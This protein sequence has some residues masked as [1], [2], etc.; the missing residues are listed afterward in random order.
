MLIAKV[1]LPIRL[2]Q[3]FDYIVPDN[4]CTIVGVGQRIKVP[5]GNRQAIGIITA[6]SKDSEFE[7]DKLKTIHSIIDNQTLFSAK[8]WQ[9]L[10]W[11]ANY[12]HYPLGEVLFHALPI[13]LRQGKL[14]AL[15]ETQIWQ[16]TEKGRHFDTQLLSRS[17]KQQALL[18]LLQ[19]D[20]PADN[21]DFSPAIFKGLQ[22]KQLI[23]KVAISSIT[24]D[25]RI[26]FQPQHMP[27]QL[28]QQQ[29]T[30]IN[31]IVR[32]SDKFTAFLL[33]GVTGSGK[34]EVYLQAIQSVLAQGRQALVLVPEIGLT[35]QTIKRFQQR[36]NVP[37][38]VLHSAMSDKA[39]LAAWLQCR[40]GDIAIVIGTRSAL[41]TPF[42]NLGMIIVDEEHDSSFK[43][44]E[45][46]RYHARDLAILRAK[47]EQI[48]IVLGS[49]TPSLETLNNAYN[50]RYRH[51]L[52]TERAGNAQLAKQT[53]LDIK[54][55]VLTA[56]LSQPL[57]AKIK[58]HLANNNQVMLFLNRRGFS[59]LLI[60]HDCGWIAECPRCDRPFTYHQKQ[61]KLICHHCDTP[62]TIPTQCP[63]CGS[64]HLVPIGFG[65]EQLEQQLNI[66]FPTIPVTRID[67]DSTQ[68]KGSL[69]QYLQA[70]GKGGKH[71]LVGTQILAK[72]HHFP[73][74]TLVG[75]V[76]VDGALF[77]SDFRAT[78]RFAQIYMQVSGR[79]GRENKTGEVILQTYHPEHPLLNNLLHNGYSAFAKQTLAERKSTLLPPFSY[80]ALIHAADRNNQ[81]APQLLQKIVDW[82]HT[83]HSD[84]SLWL[85]GPSPANQPKKAGYYRWQLL[86][87]HGQ[88]AKLQ[89]ILSELVIM[90]EKWPEAKNSRW[91]IDVDPIDGW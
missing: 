90:I 87:Q 72:G 70:I 30:A 82:L 5:F 41:F 14:A 55:L 88:R 52:L 91:S 67:R 28:N 39:R 34:T 23:E 42:S 2:H 17:I 60:C 11:A 78:E 47:I 15:Q 22:D 21:Q 35:P 18:N 80:Q 13:L 37:I 62:R 59:P 7:L 36:F 71:I 64:T 63:K 56:G 6:L 58:Q 50:Q 48:P 40:T 43:Q 1:V 65:T 4:L 79:A 46:W 86:L 26:D 9:L 25:W 29:H 83:Y 74:V 89:A 54:G 69:D 3:I 32:Q 68:K 33:E 12:Y 75:I 10:N 73:D 44:Q 38:V 81:Y 61:H 8:I 49:A 57:I 19:A 24:N 20:Q 45:G 53:I 31:E 51:L 77:S 66:L 76:D 16:L 84:P 85:L 27:F